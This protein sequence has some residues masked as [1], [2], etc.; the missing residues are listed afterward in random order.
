MEQFLS[1][2]TP[3]TVGIFF[4]SSQ[5]EVA[6]VP[7]IEAVLQHKSLLAVVGNGK[8]NECFYRDS[9]QK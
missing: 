3:V 7:K 1:L 6:A 8:A 4:C 5:V 9:T 2:G